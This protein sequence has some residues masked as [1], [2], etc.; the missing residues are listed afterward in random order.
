MEEMPS[1]GGQAITF[2]TANGIYMGHTH[3]YLKSTVAD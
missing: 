1:E 2:V 3:P